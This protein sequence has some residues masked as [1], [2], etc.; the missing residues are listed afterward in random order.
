[1]DPQLRSRAEARLQ[2]AA[3]RLGLNDPRPAYRERL[4]VLREQHPDAF[5]RAIA[6]YESAVLPALV[7]A[8]DPL[9]V[10]T[11]YGGFLARLTAEGSAYRVD[12]SG[13]SLPFRPPVAR[14]ELV[15]FLPNDGAAD[16]L[17]MAMPDAT[18]PAQAATIDLL[19]KRKL[20][21]GS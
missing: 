12:A 3:E 2:E 18:T 1:M 5:S 16:V 7:E 11:A 19:I 13:R 8:T 17:V 4:R 10:W 9:A 6:H 14:G 21:L 15:L 20:A